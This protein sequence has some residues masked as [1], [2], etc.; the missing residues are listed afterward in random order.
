MDKS[1]EVMVIRP[2]IFMKNK[3]HE[4]ISF[5]VLNNNYLLAEK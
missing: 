5:K 3:K 1:A 4:R 2:I